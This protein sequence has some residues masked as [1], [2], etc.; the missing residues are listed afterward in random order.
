MKSNN[1]LSVDAY[2]GQFDDELQNK[3]NKV[4]RLIHELAPDVSESLSYQIPTFKLKGK[5]L[6]H[7]AAY[8]THIGFYPAPSAIIAFRDKLNNYK[9]SKGAIQFPLH[10]ELP[11]ELIREIIEY[12]ISMVTDELK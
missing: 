4:R 12:R 10:D 9:T 6:A 1:A 8:K 5:P 11:L 3:L 2:I 7:F